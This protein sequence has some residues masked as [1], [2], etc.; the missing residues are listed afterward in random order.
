VLKMVERLGSHV[1]FEVFTC[2]S[3]AEAMNALSGN[4]LRAAKV[5]GIS[6]RALDRRLECHQDVDV[7]ARRGVE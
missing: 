6:R 2:P 3:G 5:L 4:R 7:P 1:G